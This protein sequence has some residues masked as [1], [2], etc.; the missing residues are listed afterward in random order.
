MVD[1]ILCTQR[2]GEKSNLAD[3]GKKLNTVKAFGRLE[4]FHNMVNLPDA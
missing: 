1:M 3:S 2:V 4:L